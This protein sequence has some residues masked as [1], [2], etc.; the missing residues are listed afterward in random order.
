[1]LRVKQNQES[2][3]YRNQGGTADYLLR[4]YVGTEFFY[5]LG[6]FCEILRIKGKDSLT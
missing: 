6:I 4:P 1:M 5:F 2:V 3:A